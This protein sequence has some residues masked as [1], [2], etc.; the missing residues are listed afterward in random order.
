MPW[1]RGRF[2]P[3]DSNGRAMNQAHS[4]PLQPSRLLGREQDVAAALA[5]LRRADVRLVTLT[6]PA[7]IGKT[8]L[9]IEVAGALADAFADG[10]CFVDLAPIRD[11]ALVSSAIAQTLGVRAVG[12]ESIRVRLQQVLSARQRLLVLDNFEQVLAAGLEL[13]ELLAA[14]AGLKLLVTSR[15]AL[16]VR[17]EHELPV[18]PLAVPDLAALPAPAD[19]ARIPAVALFVERA[20]AIKPSFRLDDQNAAA[21]AA[22]C[23]GLEGLPLAIEL[24]AVRS[25]LFA[26]AA[27]LARLTRR[28][29][30][31]TEGARDLP[32]RHQTL[33]GAIGWS[34]DLL[35]EGEQRLFRRLAVFRGGGTL[36]AA[37]AVA[38]DADS[39]RPLLD[40]IAALVDK[41]LL[42][43]DEVPGGEP[44][45]R[46]LET[47]R[48]YGL[49][50]LLASGELAAVHRRHLAYLVDLA[51]AMDAGWRG[52]DPNAWLERVE[53][54][55]ANVRAALAWSATH[56]NELELGLRLG[57]ALW[58]FWELRGH[59][60]EGRRWLTQLAEAPGAS[61]HSAARAAALNTA[62]YLA[63]FMHDL[64]AGR[65][66]IEASL[67][68]RQQINDRRGV[69]L[70]LYSLG[71]LTR[72]DGDPERSRAL[73]ERS[74]AMARALGDRV[75]T[76]IA[77]FNLAE[78]AQAQGNLA[79]AVALH[80]ESLAL[81]REQDDVWSIA[82]SW[83][84]L[85]MLA[86]Q[87]GEDQRAAAQFG[88]ALA[89]FHRLRDSRD[90]ALCLDGLATVAAA[91]GR[92]DRAA[93]L[94]GA[95][96]ASRE[97]VSAPASMDDRAARERAT[98]A[99]RA[100]L[101]EAR[102]REAWEAG[103]ALAVDT[104]VTFALDGIAPRPGAGPV[105]ETEEES[106]RPHPSALTA[107][108]LDVLR[109]LAAGK[110][111]RE[112]AATLVLSVRTVENHTASLYG[113]I[114]AHNRAEA[115]AFALR[116][117]VS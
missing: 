60:A 116:F 48:E 112:I 103:R 99:S 92:M 22:V 89:L 1:R 2:R 43:L 27:L 69:A 108:E 8:R 55:L 95:A 104:A 97:T 110:T 12:G 64:G 41:N 29:E 35:D 18:P 32:A 81:K 84:S 10:V 71:V 75:L 9:A 42:W 113:K 17:W 58:R 15:A 66:Q 13:A 52:P 5:L 4:P 24:A 16:R 61:A 31:L 45:L 105:V 109:L 67:A 85:A 80:D 78:L 91:Q 49:E 93:R 47:L 98:A 19:L 40:A 38:G 96:T 14:G 63:L 102:F 94:L 54:E 65:Q 76:Y 79:Q 28:L 37:Q 68:I 33:R 77:L 34:Y 56:E 44:R 3:D 7:G 88:Q 59:I 115:T 20:T 87:Q 23:A 107:R 100:A 25:R 82:N 73:L 90:V 26:P 36:P 101:G 21:V 46:M 114:G 57:A 72:F 74:L 50:Q 106:P 111:N 39:D 6:G 30:F 51:E 83:M 70:S 53:R 117:G 86:R 11:P 62:G